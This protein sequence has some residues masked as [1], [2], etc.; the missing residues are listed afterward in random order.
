MLSQICPGYS[1]PVVGLAG[2]AT[3]TKPGRLH[4]GG[5][6]TDGLNPQWLEER[7]LLCFVD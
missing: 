6:V 4:T 3:Q 2:Q 1:E 7:P 5:T